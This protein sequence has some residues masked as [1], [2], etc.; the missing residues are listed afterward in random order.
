MASLLTQAQTRRL[1]LTAEELKT[2]SGWPS[3]VVEDYLA[4][5]ETILSIAESLDENNSTVNELSEDKI[6]QTSQ[7]NYMRCDDQIEQ[8]QLNKRI[9]EDSHGNETTR[10]DQE[11]F[12]HVNPSR[13]NRLTINELGFTEIRSDGLTANTNIPA[14]A[15][16]Y[17]LPIYDKGGTILGYIP[18]YGSAW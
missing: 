8:S 10:E 18:V 3:Q 1:V 16:A 17:Q 12:G 11:D 15:T 7:L 4:A 14:G 2:L 9:D 6:E 13:F 5:V